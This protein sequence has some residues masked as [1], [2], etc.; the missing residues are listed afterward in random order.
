VG[1]LTI[2]E[3]LLRRVRP[4]HDILFGGVERVFHESFA[5]YSPPSPSQRINDFFKNFLKIFIFIFILRTLF[6]FI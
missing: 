6:L 1:H 4:D 2:V 5:L 3:T